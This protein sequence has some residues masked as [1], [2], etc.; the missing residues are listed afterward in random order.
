[1][2]Q[3]ILRAK[4]VRQSSQVKYEYGSLKD[5]NDHIV[6]TPDILHGNSNMHHLE[7]ALIMSSSKASHFVIYNPE[8]MSAFNNHNDIFIDGTY[9]TRPKVKGVSQ[10]LTVMAKIYDIVSYNI[11]NFGYFW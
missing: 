10:L 9:K 11:I 3:T 5:L 4:R 1:M 7:A 2:K 6:Q 8:L